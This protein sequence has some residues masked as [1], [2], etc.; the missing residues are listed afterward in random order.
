MDTAKVALTAL[1]RAN[2]PGPSSVFES[3]SPNDVLE[4]KNVLLK[5]FVL[6]LEIID[7]I[8]DYAEYWPRTTVST[9]GEIFA[10]GGHGNPREDTFVV[11]CPASRL[12]SILLK[13]LGTNCGCA[14][15]Y[16]TVGIFSRE[17]R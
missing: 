2:D 12:L 7:A 15:A 10:V 8:I 1:H 9:A 16:A 6:P 14:A 13:S 5:A 11:S 3:P 4:V 17:Y